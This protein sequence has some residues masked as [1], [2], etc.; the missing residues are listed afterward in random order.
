M[1]AECSLQSILHYAISSLQLLLHKIS[2]LHSIVHI[3]FNL[4]L[5]PVYFQLQTE[6]FYILQGISCLFYSDKQCDPF[7]LLWHIWI[8]LD[9]GWFRFIENRWMIILKRKALIVKRIPLVIHS[10]NCWL[11]LG[12]VSIVYMFYYSNLYCIT[13]ILCHY[14]KLVTHTVWIFSAEYTWSIQGLHLIV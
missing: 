12:W 2:I 6:L 7:R 14:N 1:Y 4:K 5:H 8:N 13:F 9:M 3:I 11:P 10:C